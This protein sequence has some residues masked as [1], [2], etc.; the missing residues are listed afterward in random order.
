M[1]E[2][3]PSAH[4][5]ARAE[6]GG[7]WEEGAFNPSVALWSLEGDGKANKEAADALQD[8][9]GLRAQLWAAVLCKLLG[10]SRTFC[11]QFPGKLLWMPCSW[12]FLPSNAFLFQLVSAGPVHE[13]PCL[14]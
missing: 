7:A 5:R 2:H 10:S 11:Q 12:C 4:H 13:L 3:L 8:A 9:E 1:W 14:G 6:G